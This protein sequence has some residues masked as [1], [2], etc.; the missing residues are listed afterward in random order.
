M[1]EA[2]QRTSSP[3]RIAVLG[4]GNMG[5]A[6]ARAFIARGHDVTV[7]NRNAERSRSFAG[8]CGV[9]AD[10]AEACRGAEM[11]VACLANYRATREA[12]DIPAV[13]EALAGRTLVQLSTGLPAEAQQLGD[14]AATLGAGYLDGKI[15]VTPG[16]IGEDLTVIFYAGPKVLFEAR[17]PALLSLGGRP[18]HV[19]EELGRASIADFA[20]LSFYFAGILG[21]L[22]GAAFCQAAEMDLDQFF[23]A[24]PSFTAEMV[25]RVPSFRD[26][27]SRRDYA[28]AQSTLKVD[29]A[30]ARLL[31]QVAGQ[32]GL[33]PRF[34]AFLVEMFEG[35]VGGGLG[36]ADTAALTEVFLKA[37]ARPP[38]Q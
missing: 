3:T 14:W 2:E 38:S 32:A 20:F 36:E 8:S 10:A 6:L 28:Q 24:M 34:P 19:G 5:A 7:W 29:L 12:L 15:A 18:T 21:I 31:A 33:A 30:G 9:A 17:R 26:M 23:A 27:I 13:R 4:L 37:K 35:P 25:E 16:R 22:Y 11:V 1:N